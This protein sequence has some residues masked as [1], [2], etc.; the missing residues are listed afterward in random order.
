MLRDGVGISGK[1]MDAFRLLVG[2]K[3]AGGIDLVLTSH[4]HQTP[5]M[6]TVFDSDGNTTVMISKDPLYVTHRMRT[7]VL[8]Q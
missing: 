4:A 3:A 7:E 1:Q 2:S 8:C 6:S 5:T